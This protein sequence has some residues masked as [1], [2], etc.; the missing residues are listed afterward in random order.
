MVARGLGRG[1]EQGVGG[2]QAWVSKVSI[3]ILVVLEPLSVLTVA[4]HM[5]L[6]G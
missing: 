6:I 3:R 1:L 5:P 4:G 2:T